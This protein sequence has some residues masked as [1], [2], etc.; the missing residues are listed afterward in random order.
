ML[1]GIP[2]EAGLHA[3]T[4][5][6]GH[7][8]TLILREERDTVAYSDKETSSTQMVSSLDQSLTKLVRVN[9][10]EFVVELKWNTMA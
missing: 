8:H 6:G 9:Q 3:L 4:D 7:D 10:H 5:T 2:L 1:V